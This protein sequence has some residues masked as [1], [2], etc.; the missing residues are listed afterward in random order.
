MTTSTPTSRS[1]RACLFLFAACLAFSTTL[2]AQNAPDSDEAVARTIEATLASHFK[3]DEPGATVI[4]TRNGKTL[5]RGAFGLA[6]VERKT[7]LKPDDI[8]RVGSLTKQ[9]TAVAILMLADQ[10][11]LDLSDPI[12]RH[13]ADYPKT[14][15][16]VT[17]EHLLA[18]TSGVPS[19]TAA[20]D[21]EANMAKAVS[22]NEMIARFKDL[23]LRFTP[24][25][26]WEYSNSG[27]FLLGAIIE[28]V[29]GTSYADFVAKHIFEPLAMKD[30]AYEGYERSGKKRVD[31]Y[32]D[33]SVVAPPLHMSQPYAAGSLISTVD[34]LAKWDAAIAAGK[35]LKPET[36]KRAFTPVALT[37]GSKSTYGYGWSTRK[38]QG[39]DTVSH[40]GGINGFVSFGMH[41]PEAKVYAAV[42][43]NR[44]GGGGASPSFL[45]EK[46][47]AIAAGRPYKDMKA[48][49]LD[50]AA[51]DKHIGIYK[52]DEN[53]N[54]TVTR[55]GNQLFIQRTGGARNPIAPA[56][57]TEFFQPNSFTTF[58]FETDAA[59]ETTHLVVSQASG[60]DRTPRVSKTP[61][62]PKKG[63]A[64]A[65]NVFD[66]YVGVYTI[67]PGVTMTVS[68]AGERFITQVTNQGPVEILAET[69]DKFFAK[70]IDAQIRFVKDADG[71]ASQLV[72]MQGGRETPAKR[73]P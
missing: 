42:L 57:A 1:S 54:R 58:T 23:P 5:Y 68:R 62:A 37:N 24:G 9:F 14:G 8:L 72:I 52:L 41:I 32:S 71:K 7:P 47:A 73:N 45:A 2:R 27:Y 40:A 35:L 56:S 31:G 70:D 38:V 48:I 26:R 55:E 66:Q 51:L 33:R 10:G 44:M 28:R 29:S 20:P 59:G 15:D 12:T 30:S 18:H 64:L 16:T 13:L 11:K 43:A 67:V 22:V 17:I 49:A 63:I 69:D 46:V 6:N 34:D 19:Y 36:R 21:Y 25:S 65:A 53:T 50:A 4:V 39:L 3:P 61:P 60:T